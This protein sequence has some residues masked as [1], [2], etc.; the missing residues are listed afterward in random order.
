MASQ[1]SAGVLASCAGFVKS[2]R[3]QSPPITSDVRCCQKPMQPHFILASDVGA[4]SCHTRTGSRAFKP[5]TELSAERPLAG[6]AISL[7]VQV[8]YLWHYV[9]IRSVQVLAAQPGASFFFF[10]T[11]PTAFS[12]LV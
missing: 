11:A 10:S 2:V 12:G 8:V 9:A 7:Q 6:S 1:R 4:A 5:T 3:F